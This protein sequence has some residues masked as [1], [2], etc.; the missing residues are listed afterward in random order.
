MTTKP[1]HTT[2][3]KRHGSAGR[4]NARIAEQQ[5]LERELRDALNELPTVGTKPDAVRLRQYVV[6]VFTVRHGNCGLPKRWEYATK[7]TAW[8]SEAEHQA[9]QEARKAGLTIHAHIETT[10]E[11][12]P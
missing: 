10:M 5:R 4:L 7:S 9:K 2:T 12:R 6:V 8:P 11:M 3:R 1:K